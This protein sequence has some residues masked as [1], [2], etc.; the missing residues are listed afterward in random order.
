MPSIL[1]PADIVA[2]KTNHLFIDLSSGGTVEVVRVADALDPR[3]RQPLRPPPNR[4]TT[5][6]GQA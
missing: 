4:A 3:W 5:G 1:A 6:D 2:N